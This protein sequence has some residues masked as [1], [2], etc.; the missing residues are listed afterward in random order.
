MI[1]SHI[2]AKA[3]FGELSLGEVLNLALNPG[4]TT[5]AIRVGLFYPVGGGLYGSRTDTYSEVRINSKGNALYIW[6]DNCDDPVYKFDLDSKVKINENSIEFE[7]KKGKVEL[8]FIEW[9]KG[10]IVKIANILF[11]KEEK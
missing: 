6:D 3:A 5:I 2:T 1:E 8:V 9:I 10:K 7:Y 11:N 4:I